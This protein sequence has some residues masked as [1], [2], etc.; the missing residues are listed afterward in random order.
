MC[1][2]LHVIDKQP[3]LLPNLKGVNN[4]DYPGILRILS[5]LAPPHLYS[6]KIHENPW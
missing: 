5:S 1:S 4:H 3:T 6:R 2:E